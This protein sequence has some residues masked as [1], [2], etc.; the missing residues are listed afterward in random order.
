MKELHSY[1]ASQ[2]SIAI[3]GFCAAG[4]KI[5]THGSVVRPKKTG[6]VQL[7]EYIN[8]NIHNSVIFYPMD[9]KVALEVPAY[10]GRLHPKFEENCVNHF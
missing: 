5:K 3:N 2:P 8:M 10:Q 1:L 6:C 9:A 4:I 7:R